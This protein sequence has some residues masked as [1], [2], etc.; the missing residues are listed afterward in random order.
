MLSKTRVWPIHL[1]RRAA[2]LPSAGAGAPESASLTPDDLPRFAFDVEILLDVVRASLPIVGCTRE[3]STFG[4]RTV[5]FTCARS[6]GSR[7]A[8]PQRDRE[9]HVQIADALLDASQEAVSCAMSPS[10]DI[11]P[12]ATARRAKHRGDVVLAFDVGLRCEVQIAAIRLGFTPR[13]RP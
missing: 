6:A 11:V 9:R 2:P 4:E 7:L 1:R 8:V 10:D 12:M 13:T 5:T 3:A